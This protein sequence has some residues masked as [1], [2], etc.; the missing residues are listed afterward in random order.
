MTLAGVAMIFFGGQA[1]AVLLDGEM[2]RATWNSPDLSTVID[3]VDVVVGPGV[4]IAPSLGGFGI[5][6][7]DSDIFFFGAAST[8]FA[9]ASFNGWHFFDFTGTI[10]GFGDVVINPATNLVGFD[11]SRISFD[12]D[13]IFVNFQDLPL[14]SRTVVSL[15]VI[16]EPSS[17]VLVGM[18]TVGLVFVE[19]RRRKRK[20]PSV[21]GVEAL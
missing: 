1:R 21:K 12:V 3:T 2:I 6:L 15:T 16:P 10:P 19:R 5:D 13:N 14:N 17:L 11:A 7:S 18:G 8:S 9:P 4:E 20:Q